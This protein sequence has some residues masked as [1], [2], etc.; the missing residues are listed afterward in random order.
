M[1]ITQ[2]DVDRFMKHVQ[3]QP[4]GCWRWM[5]AVDRD[6]YGVFIVGGDLGQMVRPHR[7]AY[8]VAKKKQ[9]SQI[10]VRQKCGLRLCCNPKHG[11]GRKLSSPHPYGDAHHARRHPERIL[12]GE[13][14][15]MARLTEAQVRQ[16]I[17][18]MADGDAPWLIAKR[19]G[20]SERHAH[21]IRSGERWAQ[22]PRPLPVELRPPSPDD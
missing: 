21:K 7:F 19:Y 16:M 14:H 15:K 12:R 17:Q 4:N 2:S 22:V 18:E 5:G 1:E 9:I 20:I 8:A 13:R 6:G 11:R 10:S 3:P